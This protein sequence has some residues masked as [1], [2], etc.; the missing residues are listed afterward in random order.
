MVWVE[1]ARYEEQK[2]VAVAVADA[3]DTSEPTAAHLR[4]AAP[5]VVEVNEL[6]RLDLNWLADTYA[7]RFLR[8]LSS[9]CQGHNCAGAC[10]RDSRGKSILH[11]PGWEDF[12]MVDGDVL[13]WPDVL[14]LESQWRFRI[15]M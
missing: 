1:M 10:S 14:G 4:A 8:G 5:G 3:I 13:R 9:C 7:M 11:S 2:L 15:Y 12:H 6:L